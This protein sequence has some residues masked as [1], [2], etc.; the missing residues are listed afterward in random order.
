M[1]LSREKI[2]STAF[3][4]LKQY[5]LADLSMRR[6]ATEL[7][8]AP[9]ALYYHVKNKQQ[10]LASLASRMVAE[11]DFRGPSPAKALEFGCLELFRQLSQVREAAEVIRLALAVAPESLRFVR[12][13]AGL[14]EQLVDKVQDGASGGSPAAEQLAATMLLHVC[15]SFLEEEQTRALLAGVTIAEQAPSSYIAAVQASI[16]GWSG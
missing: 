5:G 11:V 2:L 13:A 9:G 3:D 10:L 15:V 7:E 12:E 1:A 6:L 16:A 8:V 4:L 14:F